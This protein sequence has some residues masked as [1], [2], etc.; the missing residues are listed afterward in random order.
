MSEQLA[1]SPAEAATGPETAAST[2]PGP[3]VPVTP[4]GLSALLGQLRLSRYSGV[5]LFALVFATFAIWTPDTFLTAATW[6]SI[7]SA[8][9]LTA[10]LAL[11][12]LFPLAAGVFD[13]SAAQNMGFCAIVCTA[14]MVY[15]PH[16][17]VVPAI[18][19][20]LVIGSLV[21]AFNGILVSRIGVDSFIATLGTTSLLAAGAQIIGGGEYIEGFPSAFMSI[22]S[23]APFGVP[24]VLFYLLGLAVIAWYVLEHTP[25]GRRVYATGAGSD[26][27]RLAGVRTSRLVFGSFV[28]CG[29]GAALAG[30]LM[31][32]TLGTVN[33]GLGPQYLLPAFA[34]VFLGTTQLKPGRFNVW[35]TILAI[36]LLGTGVQGLQLVGGSAWVTELFNGVALIGA[37]SIAIVIERRR[38][39]REKALAA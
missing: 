5:V 27:A 23:P 20:T 19:I 11:A 7:A 17:G 10:I 28:V 32:S 4:G 33:E 24:V 6:K 39:S 37:V 26:A 36:Y 1:T 25:L 21:G 2:G 34:A 8:Q 22:A 35:G 9:A 30:V 29:F 14:L 15:Q 3:R 31:A 12:L 18:L 13:L 38:G 16:L